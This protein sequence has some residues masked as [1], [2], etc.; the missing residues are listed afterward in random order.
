MPSKCPPAEGCAL[1]IPARENGES[2]EL[3]KTGTEWEENGKRIEEQQ[4]FKFLGFPV[5]DGLQ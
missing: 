5:R 1:N 4:R 2:T 3:E